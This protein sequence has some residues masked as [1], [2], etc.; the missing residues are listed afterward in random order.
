MGKKIM[1]ID[2]E[3]DVITYLTTLLE[4]NGY[5]TDSAKDG[6]EGLKKIKE[7]RPDLVC[8]DILMPEKSGIGLYRELRKDEGLKGIP[9]VIVTGFRGDE[10]PLMDFKE[11]LY[12]RSVPGPEGYLEKPIDRQKFLE[13]IEK[14]LG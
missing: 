5:Q 12:K 9:V 1:V 7:K 14:N 2:D 4:E 10:H 6:V 8:L 3:P 11:F 13:I